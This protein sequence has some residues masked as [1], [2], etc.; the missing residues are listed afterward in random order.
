MT[1]SLGQ[2]KIFLREASGLLRS[3]TAFEGAL[4]ALSQLNFVMGLMELYA[5]GS[6]TVSQANY[7]I[8]MLISVPLVSILGIMYVL[9]GIIMPRSGGDYV[10][11]SRGLHPSLGLMVSGFMTFLA[12]AWTGLNA[13]LVGNVFLPGFFFALGLNDLA[14]IVA[15]PVNSFIIAIVCIIAFTIAFIPRT[16]VVALVL[17]ALFVA[18]FV[19]WVALVLT[20]IFPTWTLGQVLASQYHVDPSAVISQAQSSGYVPGWTLIGSAAAL[21]WAMQMWGGFWWAPYAGGEIQ[22]PKRSMWIAVLGATYIAILLYAILTLLIPH[23]FGFDLPIAL[24]YLYGANASAYPAG[25]PPP[26]IGYLFAMVTNNQVLRVLGGFGWLAS[27]LFI[28][29]SGY[30]VVTRNFF[31]WSFD[32][33]FPEPIATVSERFHTPVVSTIITGGLLCVMAYL[34]AFTSFWGYL[35]NLMIGLNFAFIVVSIAAIIFPYKQKELYQKS[36]IANW[37]FMNIP[38]IT[39]IGVA[40]LLVSGFLEY[41]VLSYPALGG[42]ITWASI[43]SVVGVLVFGLVVYFIFKVYRARQGIELRLVFGEVPPA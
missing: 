30:F 16:K 37:K 42:A 13:W 27:I 1:S 41:T 31:A 17:K 10:W 26:Y 8:A 3:L 34:T 23:A 22:N 12:L 2:P 29:P 19:G 24:N 43:G 40:S 9:F 20:A 11:V 39:L 4:I 18:T 36:P 15:Q 21:P 33:V 25:L 35:V 5:W 38:L 32:R 7:P 14:Q 6:I 28:I